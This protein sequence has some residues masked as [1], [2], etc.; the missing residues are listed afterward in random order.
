MAAAQSPLRV[1]VLGCADIAWRRTLPAMTACPDIE[2]TAVASRDEAK[3]RRFAAAFGGP[4]VLGYEELLAARDIDA[5]YIPLPTMMHA[6]WVAKALRAGKHVLAEK[7]LT[8]DAK[9]TDELLALAESRDLV[10]L[11]NVAFPHHSQHVRARQILADGAV[12][13]LKDFASVFTIPP[14][15]DENMRYRPDIGGGALLDMGIYP[16]RAALYYLGSALEVLHAVLRIRSRTGAVVSGRILACTP[17]GVTADLV[18]GMEHSYRTGCAFAG[19]SG[20]LLLD[21]AF[22]PPPSLQPVLRIERQDHREEIT[23]PVDD[24]FG[25]IVRYFANAVLT[26]SNMLDQSEMSRRQARIIDDVER[27]AVRIEIP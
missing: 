3:G 14:L 18:F 19:S 22:T 16:I 21:R 10:L 25:N 17:G 12:G 23:F 24:Q 1:G 4:R 7:P 9:S 5:V 15:P 11:E 2:V 27:V 26:G 20:L 13:E 6:D 8:G